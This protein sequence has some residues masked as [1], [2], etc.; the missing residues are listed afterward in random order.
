MAKIRADGWPYGE[1]RDWVPDAILDL[2]RTDATA[3]AF[4]MSWRNGDCSW[5]QM[6]IGLV[7][8]KARQAEASAEMA[9]EALQKSPQGF[10]V[11]GQA[12]ETL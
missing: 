11:T 5:E 3:A 7:M 9:M 2:A 12:G 10:G 1:N 4:V 8:A 6:L